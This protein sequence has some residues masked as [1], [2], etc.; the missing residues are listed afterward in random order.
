VPVLVS[1]SLTDPSVRPDVGSL[2]KAVL[3]KKV[4]EK[5]DEL[6]QKLQDTL[7]DKLKGLFR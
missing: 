7:Q 1:G 3:Q 6:K 2:A 5:K 4:D